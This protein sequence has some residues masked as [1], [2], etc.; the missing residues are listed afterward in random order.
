MKGTS[1]R[2]QTEEQDRRNADFLEND[3]KTR[4][5]NIM[6]DDLLRND[7]S[8][9]SRRGSVE[10]PELFKVETYETLHQLVSKVSAKVDEDISPRRV[11]SQ[12]FPCGSITGAPKVRTMEIIHD[13]ELEP[14]GVYTGAIGYLGPD[15]AMCLSVA[16]RTIA[17]WPDGRG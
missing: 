16:I 7:Q 2:G 6:I 12:L 9:I 3:T 10:T 4:A 15:G 11:L 1:K 5:E 17:M 8:R 14:R 13:L